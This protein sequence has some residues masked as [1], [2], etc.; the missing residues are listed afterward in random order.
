MEATPPSCKDSNLTMEQ[1]QICPNSTEMY[2][3]DF[4]LTEHYLCN[5][6]V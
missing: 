5:I 1:I 4:E 2:E 3:K 6:S